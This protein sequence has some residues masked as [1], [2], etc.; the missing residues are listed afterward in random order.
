MSDTGKAVAHAPPW[1]DP[2]GWEE[3]LSSIVSFMDFKC[4]DQGKG[5]LELKEFADRQLLRLGAKEKPPADLKDE[6]MPK[7]P[8]TV[9]TLEAEP[10]IKTDTLEELLDAVVDDPETWLSTPS[11]QLGRRKPI[12]LI[13]TDEEVKVVSL[14]QAVDQGLF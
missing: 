8:K 5:Y 1:T 12:D 10:P 14:L 3:F 11:D 4:Q 9:T 2:Q 13:G 6:I 7:R